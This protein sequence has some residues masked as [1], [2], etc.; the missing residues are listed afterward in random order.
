MG[1]GKS[2]NFGNTKGNAYSHLFTL[3]YAL[4]C[5]NYDMSGIYRALFPRGAVTM[6]ANFAFVICELCRLTGSSIFVII[7]I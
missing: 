7:Y 3:T 5:H 6:A 1:A 4:L 2:G